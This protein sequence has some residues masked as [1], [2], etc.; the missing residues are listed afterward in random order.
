LIEGP[1]ITESILARLDPRM[2][3][4]A[5][6]LFS[7]IVSVSYRLPSLFFA[8]A[9]SVM[10]VL[11]SKVPIKEIIKRSLPV[12]IIAFFL[13]LFLPFTVHGDPVFCKGPLCITQQGI[14]Y[15]T[16]ITIKSNTIILMLI[17]LVSSTPI[18]TLGHAMHELPIPKKL[19]HLLFFTF[20]YIHVI[21]SEYHRM[22]TAMKIRC[23][24]P[25]T[26]MHTY[27]TY[28]YMIGMLLVKS[29]DR[30]QRVYNAMLCRGFNNTFYSLSTFSLTHRDVF[31]FFVI[32]CTIVLMGV[33]EWK[34]TVL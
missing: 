32:L 10:V 25:K 5:V 9:V 8:L 21:Y 33:I 24:V 27:K 29:S 17:A 15:A 13:W 22:A 18:L 28:A 16:L 7:V 4:V 3:L 30:A 12:N 2:K 6:F 34:K 23:F 19:V 20:R 26:S 14:L 31:A 11:T 1:K